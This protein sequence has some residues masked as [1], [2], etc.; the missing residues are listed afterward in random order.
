M[1]KG[2]RVMFR[3]GSATHSRPVLHLIKDANTRE[4]ILGITRIG[5]RPGTM[6]LR[7]QSLALAEVAAVVPLVVGK[8][9]LLLVLDPVGG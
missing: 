2:G 3:Y 4:E 1:G 9:E 6:A 5:W 8:I 7:E